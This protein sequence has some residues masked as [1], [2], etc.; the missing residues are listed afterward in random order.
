[1]SFLVVVVSFCVGVLVR[2][3]IVMNLWNYL[4]PSLLNA[5][6]VNLAHSIALVLLIQ[7]L[8]RYAP[9]STIKQSVESYNKMRIIK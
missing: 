9:P 6:E 8:T 2:G 4:F 5:S 7:V 3:F 1:M